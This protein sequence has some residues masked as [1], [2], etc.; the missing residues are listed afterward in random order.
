MWRLKASLKFLLEFVDF[1]SQF[2]H[3]NC[4]IKSWLLPVR[5]NSKCVKLLTY[6]CVFGVSAWLAQLVKAPTSLVHLHSCIT[7][8]GSTPWV[9][10]RADSLAQASN[11]LRAVKW[12]ANSIYQRSFEIKIERCVSPCTEGHSTVCVT[13]QEFTMTCNASGDNG[14]K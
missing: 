12:V 3:S 4:S 9:H 1:R 11:L 7:V 5:V 6:C 2:L 14:G 13:L 10:F 8:R